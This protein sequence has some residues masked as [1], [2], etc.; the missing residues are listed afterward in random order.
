ALIVVG[1]AL[2]VPFAVLLAPHHFT[3]GGGARLDTA[4]TRRFD[5]RDRPAFALWAHPQHWAVCQ[6]HDTFG[7]RTQEQPAQAAPA[8]GADHDEV[9]VDIGC[10]LRD[11]LGGKLQANV[12]HTT[13]ELLAGPPSEIFDAS[14]H[15]LVQALLR[16]GHRQ[17]IGGGGGSLEL[18]ELAVVADDVYGVDFALLFLR[19]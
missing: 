14:A 10:E 9:S 12:R 6:A 3:V 17:A 4:G 11:L 1:V 2:A 13:A 15:M 8:V 18:D 16:L 7:D 5:R 19:R